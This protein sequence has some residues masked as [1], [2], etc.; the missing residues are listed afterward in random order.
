[1]GMAGVKWMAAAVAVCLPLQP[2]RAAGADA[3]C[4]IQNELIR[5]LVESEH[6]MLHLQ[7]G[8]YPEAA[9]DLEERLRTT[10]LIALRNRMEEAGLADAAEPAARMVLQQRLLLRANRV[11]GRAKAARASEDL[12]AAAA[13]GELRSMASAW[14]CFDSSRAFNGLAM[15]AAGGSGGPP[16]ASERVQSALFGFLSLLLTGGGAYFWWRSKIDQRM[17]RRYACWIP[18]TVSWAGGIQPAA[19]VNISRGGARLRNAEDLRAGQQLVLQ[20]AGAALPARVVRR[21][22]R[23]CAV[24]FDSQLS[25]AFVQTALDTYG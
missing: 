23:T 13:L 18:C 22:R 4:A 17:S 16:A 19:I 1:M 2:A 10:S 24:H 8:S 15:G 25:G 5:I 9:P 20:F 12:N 11:E 6:F 14:P 3:S 7:E 21:K